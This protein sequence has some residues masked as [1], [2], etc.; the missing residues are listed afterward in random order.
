MRRSP[1]PRR[2]TRERRARGESRLFLF[3][4]AKVA[5]VIGEY[6]AGNDQDDDHFEDETR[7]ELTLQEPGEERDEVGDDRGRGNEEGEVGEPFTNLG[8]SEFRIAA[9]PFDEDS[10]E[11]N[12]ERKRD[13]D[14]S[15]GDADALRD[16]ETLV[17]VQRIR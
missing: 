5:Q 2:P 3:L 15:E 14:G 1:Q 4:R 11:P 16:V 10:G 7:G 12:V 17:A 9:K 6:Q 8:C 13:Q